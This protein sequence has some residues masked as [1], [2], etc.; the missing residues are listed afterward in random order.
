M[1]SSVMTSC[2][3]KKSGRDQYAGRSHSPERKVSSIGANCQTV[4]PERKTQREAAIEAVRNIG[5]RQIKDIDEEIF[6]DR[7]EWKVMFF[8]RLEELK[9]CR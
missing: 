6:E 4:Y 7:T 1:I 9:G 2:M 3:V 8:R 5:L